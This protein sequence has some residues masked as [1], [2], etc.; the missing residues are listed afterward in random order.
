MREVNCEFPMQTNIRGKWR[1]KKNEKGRKWVEERKVVKSAEVEEEEARGRV[2][3]VERDETCRIEEYWHKYRVL[4]CTEKL[5]FNVGYQ[6]SKEDNWYHIIKHMNFHH[7]ICASV[8][9]SGS[10]IEFYSKIKSVS[11]SVLNFF[12]FFLALSYKEECT[13]KKNLLNP[14]LNKNL[15]KERNAIH[16]NDIL[17]CYFNL[18]IAFYKTQEG[19]RCCMLN[20]SSL[21]QSVQSETS[22]IFSFHLYIIITMQKG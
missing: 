2:E 8:D 22:S 20:K 18:F 16:S 1:K 17:F 13:G 12:F 7:C 14:S 6:T 9:L 19:E 10:E 3:G 4:K 5:I 21:L 15:K 11:L